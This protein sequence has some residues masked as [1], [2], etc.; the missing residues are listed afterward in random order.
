[1]KRLPLALLALTMSACAL[2]SPV[3][4]SVNL[5]FDKD[6]SR[7]RI[8]SVTE[9]EPSFGENAI[10]Q[11]LEPVRQSLAGER[12][13]W[14]LRFQQV[15]ADSER[16]TVEREHGELVRVEHSAVVE[17]E[18]LSRF[19]GDLPMTVTTVKGDGWAELAIYPGSSPRASRQ[20]RE[21]V[22][23]VLS[24]WSGDL[25]AY[26]NQM[27]RLYEWL[28]THP[29]MAE[30]AFTLLFEDEEKAHAVD[31]EEDALLTAARGAMNQVTARLQRKDG[32]AVPVDELFDLVY[33]PFPAEITIR[34][35][36]VILVSEHFERL[37][38]ATVMIR[39]AGLLDAARTLEGKWLSPD[40][41]ALVLRSEE[42]KFDMPK[43]PELAAM[44]RKWSQHVGASDIQTALVNAVKPAES[45]RVRWIESQ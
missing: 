38:D 28:D 45:Y 25:A 1:M 23:H 3:R 31:T 37:N 32:E 8:T 35:P 30:H 2:R 19:F 39:H 36:R 14:S 24:D 7:V 15:Q 22:E 42:D 6:P 20:Q 11:R 10:H 9:L 13:D 29:Q 43:S 21:I 40:P 34:T 18:Q 17:R 44:K 33:N 4:Y 27:S 5:D 26:F 16:V 41:L 12:D